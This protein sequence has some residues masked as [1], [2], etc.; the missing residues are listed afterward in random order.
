[1]HR[2]FDLPWPPSVNDYWG[3]G[4]R[5]RRYLKKK[6]REFREAVVCM[7]KTPAEYKMLGDLE[8]DVILIPPDA[9]KRDIDNFMK[10][11]L[12]ALRHAGVYEDDSQIKKKTVQ[13]GPSCKPG[14]FLIDI[15]EMSD[16]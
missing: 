15:W 1:M 9:R 5:G 8:I 12:D 11:P 16:A 14:R 4:G 13:F 3:N 6:A 10:G 2:H 7:N